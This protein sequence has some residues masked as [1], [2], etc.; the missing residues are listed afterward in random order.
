MENDPKVIKI[1]LD[2]DGIQLNEPEVSTR[3][4]HMPQPKGAPIPGINYGVDL[5]TDKNAGSP[6]RDKNK[7]DQFMPY[8][9]ERRSPEGSQSSQSSPRSQ[10]PL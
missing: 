9:D 7:L 10:S 3:V 2:N 1:P 4:I 8:R 5:V 6:P